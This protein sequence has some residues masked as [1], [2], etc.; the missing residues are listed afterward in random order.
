MS[1]PQ[2]RQLDRRRFLLSLG[3][4]AAASVAVPRSAA[5]ASSGGSKAG[6]LI[7]GAGAHRYEWVR[8]WGTLP[9]GM[10][11]G[12]MHGGVAVDAQNHVYFST[13]GDASI[14]VFDA[15]GKFVRSMGKEW[16][17]DKPGDGTHELYLHR[18]GGQEFLYLTSLFRHEFAKL[19][20]TGEVVW[21]KG[22]PEA[23]GLYK[24]KDEFKP[25][26]IAVAPTGDVY[27]AD[28]YGANYLH[29]YGPR[30]EYLSSWGGKS[31]QAREPGKFDT[32]HKVI[33]DS[34]GPEPS[35]LVTDR[36]NHR[37]Q[38][39]TREGKH[40]KT[41]D[42]T[43]NDFLRRPA[44]LSIRGTDV[45]IADLKGRVTIL[46]RDDKLAAQL[47]DSGQE[48]KQATNQVAPEQWV[49]GEFIAPHGVS[50]DAGG[51]LYVS[52]WAAAGRVVK[53]ARVSG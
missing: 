18:E 21:V 13:D 45:A 12:N 34:R 40:L 14:V 53:L 47:G 22:F 49:D 20:T 29:R 52:E 50:F 2:G 17:P 15:D 36:E 46:D 6:A 30:G 41:L 10:T 11:L 19:T 5:A 8:G 42:G 38:W 3:A 44:A 16:I 27:V 24:A 1:R 43:A 35:V 51:N 23:S 39:F 48:K 9:A 37:L 28:G 33:V 32:A 4:G 26:G 31:T 25:T 7:L